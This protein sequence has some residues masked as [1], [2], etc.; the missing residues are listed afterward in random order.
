[1]LDGAEIDKAGALAKADPDAAKKRMGN[2]RRD[3]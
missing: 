1:V 3:F 2:P